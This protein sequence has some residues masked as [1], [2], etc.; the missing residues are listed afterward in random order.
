[1]FIETEEEVGIENCKNRTD[2]SGWNIDDALPIISLGVVM[3]GPQDKHMNIRANAWP[4][5]V[6]DGD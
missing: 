6:D 4:A 5:Q 2:R 3:K 1:M